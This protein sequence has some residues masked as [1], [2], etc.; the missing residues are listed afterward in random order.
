M[1]PTKRIVLIECSAPH[2]LDVVERMPSHGAEVIYW[3][4]WFRIA[5]EVR[6]KF[7][8]VTFHDTVHAK[9]ALGPDGMARPAGRFDDACAAVWSGEAATIYDMMNRFDH[10]RDQSFVERSTLLYD[11]LIYW[12]GVLGRLVPDL[13][14]F[15]TPPHVVY[16]YVILA[17]CR[18]LGLKTLM[19][20]E[21]TI[22]PPYCLSMSDYREG[23]RLAAAS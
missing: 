8:Q 10:S 12:A 22:R 16:D 21:A 9:I 13:V 1:S 3:T 4:G 14:V 6:Q 11:H 19:F 15:S 17:L 5:G 2:W 20:E 23:S 18:E 7:P